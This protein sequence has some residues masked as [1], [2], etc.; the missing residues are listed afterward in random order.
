MYRS[1][2]PIVK[3]PPPAPAASTAPLPSTPAMSAA[4][5]QALAAAFEAKLSVQSQQPSQPQQAK[6]HIQIP[7][8]LFPAT[9]KPQPT[10]PQSQPITS[11]P[12]SLNS[13]QTLP[14]LNIL[15]SE[16]VNGDY[17]KDDANQVKLL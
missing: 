5:Q 9:T 8:L 13:Q 2:K 16:T 12:Q 1:D 10:S 14:E 6:P 7:S 15:I 4:E 11:L 17:S 3:R